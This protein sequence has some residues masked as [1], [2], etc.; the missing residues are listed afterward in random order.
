M[1]WLEMEFVLTAQVCVPS[2]RLSPRTLFRL[3]VF[4]L[5]CVLFWL[6]TFVFV[7]EPKNSCYLLSSPIQ[8]LHDE[9]FLIT[10]ALYRSQNMRTD[11]PR[12]AVGFPFYTYLDG[13]C[14]V[15]ALCLC[16]CIQLQ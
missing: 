9:R 11:E 1:G 5:L 7:H 10:H 8:R 15:S 3:Q 6:L 13:R 4:S 16:P 2:F 14:L 12:G